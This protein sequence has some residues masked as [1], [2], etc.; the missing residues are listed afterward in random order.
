MSYKLSGVHLLFKL[1]AVA[2][3]PVCH[4]YTPYATEL[5]LLENILSIIIMSLR[6]K[7]LMLAIRALVQ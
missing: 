7:F 3:Y 4:S 5:I 6:E 2:S 1:V